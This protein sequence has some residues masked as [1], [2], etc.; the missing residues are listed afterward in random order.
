MNLKAPYTCLAILCEL[1]SSNSFHGRGSSGCE[2]IGNNAGERGG[3]SSEPVDGF[4]DSSSSESAPS[5][6]DYRNV[7]TYIFTNCL[8]R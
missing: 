8:L 4:I 2:P 5:E 3:V 1:A 7:K 6:V